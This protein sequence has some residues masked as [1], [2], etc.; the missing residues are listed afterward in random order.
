MKLF[1][2]SDLQSTFA[3]V[4]SQKNKHIQQCNDFRK[5]IGISNQG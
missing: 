2:L 4:V 5:A 3:I 1:R